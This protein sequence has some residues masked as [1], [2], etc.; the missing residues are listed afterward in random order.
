[1]GISAAMT[2]HPTQ[3]RTVARKGES[4]PVNASCEA[5]PSAPNPAAALNETCFCRTLDLERL[6]QQVEHGT[7]QLGVLRE[8]LRSR[9]HLFSSTVVFISTATAERMAALVAAIT[10]VAALPGYQAQALARADPLARRDFGPRGVCM[11]FDFHLGAQGPQL[12]EVNTNAGGLLLNIAL[13]RA[14]QSC[15]EA[16]DRIFRHAPKTDQIEPVVFEMFLGEWRLQHKELRPRLVAIVD[17][18]PQAQYLAPEFELF[19]EFFERHGWPAA[20]CDPCALNWRDSQLWLGNRPV[21]MVYNRLTDFYLTEPRHAALRQAADAGAVVITPHARAHALFADKRNLVAL[22]Q[23]TVLAQWGVPACDRELLRQG[24]PPTELVSPNNAPALWA[25]RRQLFFKPVA[26]F[27]ARAAYRGDKLTRRVWADILAGEFVAQSLV[28]PA[29]R[30]V[31][32]DG[33]CTDLKFDLRAY[34]Y[35]GRMQ[36]LAAR[37]YAGQTTNFRTRGGGFSPVI[38]LPSEFESGPRS[39]RVGNDGN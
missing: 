33:M 5:D 13:A 15:C 18:D 20:I 19:R 32:V 31:E 21:D 27:G 10:R 39:S 8:I 35:D 2:G 1:M 6:R 37:M 22:S 4:V 11:G 9:P 38:V 34:A 7:G 17:D 12:I 24:I 29:G 3:A 23:D 36:W 26:G 25:R 28:P 30:L 16:M 14:Q